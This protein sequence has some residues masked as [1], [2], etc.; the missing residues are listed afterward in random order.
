MTRV[1]LEEAVA[2]V[3]SEMSEATSKACVAAG[4]PAA[5][6]LDLC[7][8][9][10]EAFR[11]YERGMTAAFRLDGRPSGSPDALAA[12]VAGIRAGRQSAS[13]TP[14]PNA[15]AADAQ[16]AADPSRAQK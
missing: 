9:V 16:A 3:R 15:P 12:Y 4:L 8:M 5:M 14:I 1:E 2:L 7:S 13:P 6:R 10:I 11:V